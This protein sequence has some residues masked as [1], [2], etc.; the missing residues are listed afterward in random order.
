LP[1]TGDAAALDQRLDAECQKIAELV[2]GQLRK[3]SIKNI[4]VKLDE[5]RC[6]RRMSR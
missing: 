1:G 5:G 2:R 3:V 6:G 4:A